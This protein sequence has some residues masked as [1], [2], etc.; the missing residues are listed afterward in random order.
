[1]PEAGGLAGEEAEERDVAGVAATEADDRADERERVREAGGLAGEEAEERDVAGVAAAEA[2]FSK[3]DG[4]AEDQ[5]LAEDEAAVG[6]E[7]RADGRD[8]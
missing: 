3:A 6:A 8:A 1:M 4:L 5:G 2:F 7:D